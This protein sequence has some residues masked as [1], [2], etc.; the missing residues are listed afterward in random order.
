MINKIKEEMASDPHW[1]MEFQFTIKGTQRK[2]EQ[3]PER[4]QRHTAE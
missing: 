2:Y 3:S 1:S 4:M